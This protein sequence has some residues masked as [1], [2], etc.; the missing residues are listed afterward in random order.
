MLEG[1]KTPLLTPAEDKAL[2]F[3]SNTVRGCVVY[4]NNDVVQIVSHRLF[5]GM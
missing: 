1:G 3:H 2:G 5:V 4:F